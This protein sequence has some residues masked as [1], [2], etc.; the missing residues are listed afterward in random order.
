MNEIL[1]GNSKI[2]S[3]KEIFDE[4]WGRFPFNVAADM[5]FYWRS[6]LRRYFFS[7]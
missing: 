6:K 3:I 4:D 5:N 1:K 2:W 7:S